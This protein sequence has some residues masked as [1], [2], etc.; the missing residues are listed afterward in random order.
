LNKQLPERLRGNAEQRDELATPH[1]GP[2]LKLR[3]GHY[4]AVAQ[5]R[6]RA[7]QQKLRDDVADGSILLKKAS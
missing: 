2:L 4:H 1:E 5:G 6:R 3:A 7:S